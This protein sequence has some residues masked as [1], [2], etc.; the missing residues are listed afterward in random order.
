MSENAQELVKVVAELLPDQGTALASRVGPEAMKKAQE[1]EA[2][3]VPQ[4]NASPLYA[5]LWQQFEAAP[6]D[7]T[8]LLVGAVQMLLKADAAL[9][10]RLDTLLAE[11]RQLAAPAASHTVNTG[12]GAYIGGNVSLSG[13]SFVGRDQ[14]NVT[15]TGNGNVMGDH[16]HATVTYTSGMGGDQAAA[17]FAQ[18]LAL[19]RQQ[20]VAVR[21]ELEAAVETAQEETAQGEEAD[22]RLLSKMLDVLLEK[23]PDILEVVIDAILNPAA[24]AGKGAKLLAKQAQEALARKQPGGAR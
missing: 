12:G 18:A 22:K 5:P 19:A 21:D 24:A 3:L 15:I 17:L 8:P 11:Y 7:T 14:R 10:R 9:A 13:G 20:P 1:I 6:A 4:F 23:G 16:S 2:V